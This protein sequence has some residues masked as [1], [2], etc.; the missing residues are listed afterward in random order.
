M[1]KLFTFLIFLSCFLQGQTQSWT[2][3][4]KQSK[5]N[6]F[7]EEPNQVWIATDAGIFII[8][9]SDYSV[10][11]WTKN[12]AG[13]PS[14]QVEKIAKHP[15]TDQLFIGTYDIGIGFKSSN[16]W[17]MLPYPEELL[18][19]Q[20]YPLTYCFDW[21]DSGRLWVGTN[22]GLL[23]YDSGE[24]TIIPQEGPTQFL[25]QVWEME[26]DVEGNLLVG[27]NVL[28]KIGND[29]MELL[30]PV[31]F[32]GQ[33]SLFAYGFAHLHVQDNGVIWFFTD[34]GNVGR[35]EGD[36]LDIFS[37]FSG[38]ESIAFNLTKFIAE[39]G[40]GA[41]WVYLDGW[42][43]YRYDNDWEQSIFAEN[44]EED[45]LLG[46]HFMEDTP[47]LVF[48]GKAQ[49]GLN[50]DN[51]VALVDYPFNGILSNMQYD[52][53]GNMWLKEGNSTLRQVDLD[54]VEQMTYEGTPLVFSDYTLAPDGT[55]WL[56]SGQSVYHQ[57]ET[58]WEIFNHEN[59]ALPEAYGFR[60]IVAGSDGH[61]WV[62][63]YDRGI[64]HYDGQVWA[65]Y[66]LPIPVEHF[67]ASMVA[68]SDGNIWFTSWDT[69]LGNKITR[70][71]EQ[72]YKIYNENDIGLDEAY[73]REIFYES[74]NDRLWL[75]TGEG[76]LLTFENG[77][78]QPS[79]ITIDINEIG[80]VSGL[81]VKNDLLVIHSN[82]KVGLY[83]NNLWTVFDTEN[84]PLTSDP[85]GDIG[86]DQSG[87]LWIG[88]YGARAAIEIYQTDVIISSSIEIGSEVIFTLSPN[89][90]RET[91]KIQ[92]DLEQKSSP[93]FVRIYQMDGQLVKTYKVDNFALKAGVD[94]PVDQLEA[95]MYYL[96]V[97]VGKR[98]GK[99]FIKL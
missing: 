8:D 89:P 99:R 38:E 29:S 66:F 56:I 54:E 74:E 63:V 73:L 13:L 1:Y 88:H 36:S 47:I 30:T 39:D 5:V 72:E 19:G 45:Q 97:D 37:S 75:A 25:F 57:T 84:S 12:N 14:N 41:L 58:G 61:I 69:Y 93:V 68:G 98:I 17:T 92:L 40:A 51:N 80:I 15:E 67:V 65:R 23:R 46:L 91:I 49:I 85:I 44:V 31:D 4:L 26:K 6:D 90:A 33:E 76:E 78:W 21:D 50:A 27:G 82:N 52:W 3:Y 24:W 94:F 86:L 42:G 71:N 70:L 16:G 35:F 60:H 9:K 48:P 96:E 43:F 11:H 77:N 55:V 79:S 22:Q 10:E 53:Q 59:T 83:Q 32:I 20:D 2:S 62:Q 18:S 81:M 64:Y 95:G 28:V 7:F 87:R 34:I